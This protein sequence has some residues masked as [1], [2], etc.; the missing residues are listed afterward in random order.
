[1]TP[2]IPFGI[3]LYAIS[4]L[5]SALI[6]LTLAF[7]FYIH[8]RKNSVHTL[9]A[10]W[11]LSVSVWALG[12]WQQSLATTAAA[13]MFWSGIL[14]SSTAM[15]PV[16]FLDF[17]HSFLNSPSRR[18]M[19]PVYL[20][21]AVFSA[22]ALL[23]TNWLIAQVSPAVGFAFYPQAGPLYPLYLAFFFGC[24]AYG[25]SKLW[26]EGRTA[27]G[28]RRNQI[29]YLLVATVIGFGGGS[30][31]FLPVIG[32]HLFPYGNHGMVVVCALIIAYA[33]VRYRLMEISLVINK[34]LGYAIV[35]GIIVVA[36][37][38]GAVLSNR[39]T[40]HSVPPLLT[41]TLF[42]ICGLWVL[43]NG[44]RTAANVTFA[45]LCGAACLWLVG[46][47][48]LFSAKDGQEA[49]FWERVIYAG[50]VYIPVL[51]YHFTQCLL[52][53]AHK[54]RLL[55]W[56]YAL[57]T[58]FWLL[59][60]S[61]LLVDGYYIYYWGRYPKAGILHPVFVLYLA[62][63]AA[64]S[65]YR[66]YQGYRASVGSP[67]S[68]SLQLKYTFGALLLGFMAAMDFLQTYG[69]DF[70]PLGYLSAGLSVITVAYTMGKYELMD[71]SLVPSRPKV[72]L[73]VKLL[74]L[75]PAYLVIL[76]IIRVFTGTLHYLLAGVLFALFVIIAGVL[77]NLQQGVE[78][79]IGRTLFRKRYDAYDTLVQ[80]SK[81]LVSILELKPLTKEIVETL[82]RVMNI[83]TASVFVLYKEQGVYA[84]AARCGTGANDRSTEVI[85]IDSELIREL[86]TAETALVQEEVAYDADEAASLRVLESLRALDAEVCI[87]L[88]NKDRLVGFCNLGQRA[89]Q[90]MYS[91]EELGLLRTLAQHA[92]I[93]ID[94]AL[95]YEDLRRSQLLMRRTDRLRSLETMAGG[96]AHEIRNPLTSIKTFIQLA[97]HRRDDTEFMEQFGQVVCDDVERIE[98]LIHEILDYARYMTPKLT[99]ENLNDVVSSCLYFI[100]VKAGSK[101]IAI[102][103]HLD[104][105]VPNV[106]LD[107][108]QIKQVLLNLFLNAVEAIGERG[109]RLSVRTRKRV[110]QGNEAWVQ[111]EVE[112]SGPGILPKDLEHIFDPFYSTKHTSGEREGTGLGLTIA[113][114]II[115]EHG[116]Y[117]EV[118]SEIDRGTTFFVNLPV[119]P[120]LG[121]PHAQAGEERDR[122]SIGALI[123]R[124]PF[125]PDG[126]Y[127]AMPPSMPA[128]SKETA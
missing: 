29:N 8:R 124:S 118:S 58:G 34:A 127:G 7:I 66:L 79:T 42:F 16:L 72:L 57:S 96:F 41:G 101:G 91:S 75:I 116:G 95:L 30:T 3:H 6:F 24:V 18:H 123:A 35:L 38:I 37:S 33:I 121:D 62:A 54:D 56:G 15:I 92:A 77:T 82:A 59:S 10:L 112:D 90:G 128:S 126:T 48:M 23:H 32:I 61:D 52:K 122:T 102:H 113:H 114:Q 28:L 70:Y 44:V 13:G 1:M 65:L 4:N 87:P 47:F 55:I 64:M 11:C 94:N 5:L 86:M 51:A 68:V 80:F 84:L 45:A 119:D 111:I 83:T 97:P 110:K 12:V 2:P 93:A 36:T 19:L 109:G 71:V 108:Q 43:G 25:L 63:G 76:V 120:A 78:R 89:N 85:Q 98:R 81:S 9:F 50:V 46:C 117:I 67:G 88:L 21:G 31:A 115:Q 22:I 14:H 74:A 99:V 49:L 125:D 69:V 53:A 106:R 103:R 104:G 39:A 26:I 17:V 20:T 107:R 27:T 73:S 100:E 40:A 60:F 105:E